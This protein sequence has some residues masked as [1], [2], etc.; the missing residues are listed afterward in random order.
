MLD[1][2]KVRDHIKEFDLRSKLFFFNSFLMKET[3]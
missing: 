3:F 2:L 1:G